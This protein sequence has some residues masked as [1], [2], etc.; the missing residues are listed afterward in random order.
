ML[1][2]P[3]VRINP[4]EL[5]I[6]DPDFYD[7]IYSRGPNKRDKDAEFVPIFA[8]P[9]AS[10][11]AVD[12]DLHKARARVMRSYFS[13]Q[14]IRKREPAITYCIDKLLQ[15][16]EGARKTGECVTL[17]NAF[18]A[19]TGDIITRYAYGRDLGFLDDPE[20]KLRWK[21]AVS[22]A[23]QAG[24]FFR[25]FPLLDVFK[26]M[27]E[28]LV[29]ALNPGVAEILYIEHLVREQV[30]ERLATKTNEAEDTIF[31]ALIDP[32][33]PAEYKTLDRLTDEGHILL[34][35]GSET[36]ANTLT[37]IAFHLLSNPPILARLREELQD[38]M[39]VRDE[40]LPWSELEQLPFLHGVIKEGLRLG[41]GVSSRLPRVAPN[42]NLQCGEWI[43]PAGTPMSTMT[44]MMHMNPS[45]FPNPA[46]FDP[47]R[48]ITA[49]KRG[50]SLERYLVSFTRGTRECI[51][52]R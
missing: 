23:L 32:S 28:W 42:E 33:V 9:H 2:G 1:K 40:I 47:E 30:R 39:P 5:H 43:I 27:P 14:S 49:S 3:V 20:F 50:Q 36:T 4:R 10:I 11:A 22:G 41:M 45:I 24:V 18:N 25:F 13:Q 7:Q 46:K 15:R 17:N 34:I 29:L 38:A 26:I 52:I 37:T 8:A 6:A 19:M 16:F 35:G 21:D 31:D 44:Y 51:G 12:H 48:W